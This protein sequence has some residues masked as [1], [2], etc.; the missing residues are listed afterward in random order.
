MGKAR[1]AIESRLNDFDPAIR[2]A[3]LRELLAGKSPAFP[4]PGENVNMHLHSFYSYNSEGYSPLRLVWECRRAGLQAAALCDFDVLL[5]LEEFL[6]AGR[7]LGLRTSVHLETRAYVKDYARQELSSPG[8]P[9][10]TYIMG[11]GFSRMPAAGTEPARELE[12]YRQRARA[13]NL[14]VVGRVNPHMGPVAIDYARDVEP[15]TPVGTATERHIISAYVHRA[16]AVLKTPTAVAA[17]WSER[18]G[19]PAEDVVELMADRPAF[20]ELVRS[21][22]VKKGSVGYQQP[23]PTTFPAIEDFVRWVRSCDA[24]PMITW[25]DGTSDGEA[26][27][28][29]LLECLEGMGCAAL[30]I[31]PDR[32]WNIADPAKRAVKTAKLREIVAEAVRMDLPVNIGTEMNKQGLPFVDDLA[33]EAL[34]PYRD[35]FVAGARVMV[36]QTLLARY[37][38]FPY[39]GA[40]AQAAYPTRRLRN[41]F[42]GTVGA[43]TA[44]DVRQGDALDSMGAEKALRWFEDSVRAAAR[45]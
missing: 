3:A 39:L 21:K 6:S 17:F 16:I 14:D 30:N 4:A 27:G 29:K 2:Q 25:L 31:V 23:S 11:G 43:L 10:V 36:G 7:T 38:G 44:L 15:L 42:F 37:A 35:V 34:K 18:L 19:R 8:E 13:R 9:G 32:N 5:G 20:E 45:A 40:A 33:G 22:L 26:D 28:R 24:I 1:N 41:G 12:A